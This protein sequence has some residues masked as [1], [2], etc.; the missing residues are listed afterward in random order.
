M[1]IRQPAFIAAIGL[2]SALARSSTICAEAA[3]K[4]SV[5]APTAIVVPVKG[6]VF[7]EEKSQKLKVTSLRYLENGAIISTS[8][9]AIALLFLRTGRRYR[10]EPASRITLEASSPAA[11]RGRLTDLGRE[12]TIP[13]GSGPI[14]A[15]GT[16]AAATAI[17]GSREEDENALEAWLGPNTGPASHV[18]RAV[19]FRSQGH[20]AEACAEL[21]AVASVEALREDVQALWREWHCSKTGGSPPPPTTP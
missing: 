18:L 15:P 12:P 11:V 13:A 19:F 4:D 9:E 8:S 5:P 14:I 10:I 21:S 1:S 3:P 2:A 20:Y 17:R 6:D 16:N 7:V